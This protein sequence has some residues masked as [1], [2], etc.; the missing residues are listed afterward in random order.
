M[1]YGWIERIF[2]WQN[3]GKIHHELQNVTRE[4]ISAFLLYF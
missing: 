2:K 4:L 3:V 1:I